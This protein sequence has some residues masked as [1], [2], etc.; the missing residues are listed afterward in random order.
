MKFR[1]RRDNP[2]DVKPDR[3]NVSVGGM[4]VA[5]AAATRAPD[6]AAAPR[7]KRARTAA[8]SAGAAA[9]RPSW[10]DVYALPPLAEDGGVAHDALA[11]ASDGVTELPSSEVDRDAA[12]P[13]GAPHADGH[14]DKT[15]E[16]LAV[17][18]PA[19]AA[20]ARA[21]SAAAMRRQQRS[22]AAAMPPHDGPQLLSPFGVRVSDAAHAAAMVGGIPAPQRFPLSA[23]DTA[24]RFAN[25]QART[26]A[27]KSARLLAGSAAQGAAVTALRSDIMSA[28]AMITPHTLEV[29]CA[30]LHVNAGQH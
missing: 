5:A 6:A 15:P 4:A 12:Q 1:C 29:R 9:V 28:V 30:Q 2:L 21:L 13:Q 10:V 17:L 19:G 18:S 11:S 8:N 26:L 27:A 24:L 7:P 23:L 3:R 14:D 16:R 22:S 20:A 25:E